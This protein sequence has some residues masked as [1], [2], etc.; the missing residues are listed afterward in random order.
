M[1]HPAEPAFQADWEKQ[2]ERRK[3][4]KTSNTLDVKLGTTLYSVATLGL[5]AISYAIFNDKAIA[6]PDAAGSFFA[7][8]ALAAGI[9]GAIPYWRTVRKYLLARSLGH[10]EHFTHWNTLRMH[11][12]WAISDKA[13]YAV[14]RDH[15]TETLTV[16]RIPSTKYRRMLSV[17]S[18]ALHLQTSTSKAGNFFTILD[19]NER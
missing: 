10:I 6:D 4:E 5:S 19:P 11:L 18:K 14:T 8:L 9:I 7:F 13:V 12:A 17:S 15:K 3:W 16:N 2:T 1:F